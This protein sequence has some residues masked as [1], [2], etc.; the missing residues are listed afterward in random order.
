MVLPLDGFRGHAI[1]E[2]TFTFAPVD[3]IAI[4]R[5]FLSFDIDVFMFGVGNGRKGFV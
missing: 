4:V 2:L 1:V 3:N 5:R